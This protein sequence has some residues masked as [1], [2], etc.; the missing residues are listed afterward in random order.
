MQTTVDQEN[1]KLKKKR[2]KENTYTGEEEKE[3]KKI[4]KKQKRKTQRPNRGQQLSTTRGGQDDADIH[5]NKQTKLLNVTDYLVF[6]AVSFGEPK[7]AWLNSPIYGVHRVP[8][9][10]KGNDS[11]C[12]STYTQTFTYYTHTNVH[13]ASHVGRQTYTRTNTLKYLDTQIGK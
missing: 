8:F 10:S 5:T 1:T 6:P 3:E 4:V 13:N 12:Q 2:R 9:E 7:T 11:Q